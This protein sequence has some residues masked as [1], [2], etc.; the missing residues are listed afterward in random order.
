MLL[1][2]AE[3]GLYVAD[4]SAGARH[5]AFVKIDGVTNIYHMLAIEALN[6]LLC[7]G[8]KAVFLSIK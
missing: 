6:T 3:E 4:L 2:G 7:I 8:G 5:K 1:I